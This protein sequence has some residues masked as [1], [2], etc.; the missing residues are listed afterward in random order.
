MGRINLWLSAALVNRFGNILAGN[1]LWIQRDAAGNASGSV[2]NS[3]GTIETQRGDITVRTETLTNQREGLTVTESSSSAVDMPGWVGGTT[4]Y[5][6][7]GFFKRGYD[8]AVFTPYYWNSSDSN[9]SPVYYP[10]PLTRAVSQI[11]AI[12]SKTVNVAS[13]GGP[14]SINSAG[15]I[16]IASSILVNDALIISSG[17]NILISGDV[18]NNRSYQGGVLSESL[19]YEYEKDA[20]AVGLPDNIVQ[21]YGWLN[22]LKPANDSDAAYFEYLNEIEMLENQGIVFFNCVIHRHRFNFLSSSSSL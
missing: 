10:F 4:I 15:N 3:S 20:R 13:G 21:S 19:I 18:L 11:F 5:I 12:S 7:L 17:K 14:S 2:L 9:S 22:E 16:S 1:S 8:Y 6:P